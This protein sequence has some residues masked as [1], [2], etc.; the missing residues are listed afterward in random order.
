[1][2]AG[3][4]VLTASDDG[5]L[6]A[7][8]VLVNEHAARDVRSSLLEVTMAD[9]AVLSLTPDHPLYI[10][11][12]LR[13]ARELTPGVTLRRASGEAVAVVRAATRAGT[14]V[15]PVTAA[16]TLLAS[17]GGAP[18]LAGS[19]VVLEFVG[20]AEVVGR[21]ATMLLAYSPIT[22]LSY[23]FP[24]SFQWFWDAVVDPT[25]TTAAFAW[26]TWGAAPLALAVAIA[27]AWRGSAAKRKRA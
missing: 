22:A 19:F 2:T 18:V 20:H 8:R 15:N 5:A 9:G 25:F 17:D 24:S 27:G 21:V 13:A 16:G 12:R 6:A 26:A 23:A 3:D 4:H 1:M 14:V 7:T 11:G 10:D